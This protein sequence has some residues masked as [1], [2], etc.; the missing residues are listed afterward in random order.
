MAE[1]ALYDNLPD[2]LNHIEVQDQAMKK[3]ILNFKKQEAFL[4]EKLEEIEELEEQ[5]EEIMMN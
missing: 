4:Q 2:A 3:L 5:L 1:I